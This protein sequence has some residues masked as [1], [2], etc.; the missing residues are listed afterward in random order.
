MASSRLEEGV[1]KI[2]GHLRMILKMSPFVVNEEPSFQMS[3]DLLFAARAHR[4][5]P[6]NKGT[7]VTCSRRRLHTAPSVCY[8]RL[9][10]ICTP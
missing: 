9:S 8:Y 3:I 2:H 6:P 10:I 1:T 4:M 5:F 7:L